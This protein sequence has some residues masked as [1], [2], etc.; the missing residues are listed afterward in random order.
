MT[1][2][3]SIRKILYTAQT[4]I[5]R[6]EWKDAANAFT[7]FINAVPEEAHAMP[8]LS[9]SL[10]FME[11]KEYAKAIEDAEVVLRLSDVHT[12]EELL[13]GCYSTRAAASAYLAKAH[14]RL[15]NAEESARYKKLGTELLQADASNLEKA[16][17]IKEE[18][19][20]LYRAGQ[21]GRAL[22]KYEEALELNPVEETVLSNACQALIKLGRLD[23]AAV[24]ADRCV[25]AKPTWNKGYYR[26]GTVAIK[27]RRFTDAISAFQE[28]LRHHPD[29]PDLRRSYMEAARMA[30]RNATTQGGFEKRVMGM[31]MEIQHS[32]WK[33]KEWFSQC[34]AGI[35]W[36][37]QQSW[38]KDCA[39]HLKNEDLQRLV[40]Q[41]LGFL[42]SDMTLEQG[43]AP[44]DSDPELKA[45]APP[46]SLAS[47]VLP[48]SPLLSLVIIHRIFTLAYPVED[49]SMVWTFQADPKPFAKSSLFPFISSHHSYA[50]LVS[51]DEKIVVDFLAIWARQAGGD[52]TFEKWF[53]NVCGGGGREGEAVYYTCDD[54]L[55]MLEFVE[56]LYSMEN[57]SNMPREKGL[58]ATEKPIDKKPAKEETTP[59]SLEVPS[60]P[61]DPVQGLNVA[62]ASG[63]SNYF[64]LVGKELAIGA[65][66]IVLLGIVLVMSG[67]IDGNDVAEWISRRF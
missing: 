35:K 49:W 27:Q 19:N 3:A 20:L 64:V 44:A 22:K 34:H 63:I 36:W 9:R 7:R 24:M 56:S 4:A 42:G 28:G 23:E 25:Y 43:A 17:Q 58:I 59:E 1:D 50:V 31:M 48:S 16:V 61:S 32:S 66:L 30:E 8:R 14:D 26:K 46:H 33:V 39:Q 54:D 47:Y 6:K 29:D 45:K 15:G 52:A 40:I 53:E 38:D 13:P 37:N 60:K 51:R 11:Q 21:I 65:V 10:C 55:K 67:G 62:P 2:T 18:G 5:A 41:V 57:Q 12:P